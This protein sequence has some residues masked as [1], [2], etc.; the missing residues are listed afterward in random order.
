MVM[1]MIHEM[2]GLSDRE[3]AEILVKMVKKMMERA[4]QVETINAV[5]IGR[6]FAAFMVGFWNGINSVKIDPTII[7]REVAFV[8]DIMRR[9]SDNN[10]DEVINWL[11][12]KFERFR[13]EM[14]ANRCKDA[15]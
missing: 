2:F 1:M 13:E 5:D 12:S 10:D 7:D 6:E 4:S 15:V 8:A 3:A 11:V 9:L 14:E